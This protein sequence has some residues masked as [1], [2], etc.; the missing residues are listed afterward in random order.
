M[1]KVNGK[2]V[3]KKKALKLIDDPNSIVSSM[4]VEIPNLTKDPKSPLTYEGFDIEKRLISLAAKKKDKT[5]AS[6]LAMS[7]I[8][9]SKINN[10][11]FVMLFL[12]P[13]KDLTQEQIDACEVLGINLK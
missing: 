11:T 3:S 8:N 7:F 5:N 6:T 1:I 4:K 13:L 12:S 9:S 2:K 10:N